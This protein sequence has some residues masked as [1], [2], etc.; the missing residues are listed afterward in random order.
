MS[1]IS[2]WIHLVF[3]TK[4]RE[5]FL[6]PGIRQLVFQHIKQNA[7]AKGIY[8][9]SINGFSD[10]AHGLISLNKDQNISNV[11]QLIKGESSYWINKNNMTENKF[12]WQ[13]DYWATSVSPSH[14][15]ATRKYILNQEQ[16]HQKKSFTDE[17][18]EF[19]SKY[20]WEYFSSLQR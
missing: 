1:W 17:I 5:P 10:H 19:V 18:D 13:D 7:T 15:P 12:Q 14:V 11:V 6:H 3:T 2:I 4:N 16:H 8:L 9:D 20:G